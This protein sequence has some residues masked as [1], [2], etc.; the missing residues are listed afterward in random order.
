LWKELVS[1]GDLDDTPGDEAAVL[2]RQRG[3]QRRG[4]SLGD[5]RHRAGHAVNLGT[6]LAGDGVKIRAMHIIDA[7]SSMSLTPARSSRARSTSSAIP[8]SA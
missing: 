6:G 1:F 4:A 2:Q 3:R 8:R 7:S 5:R